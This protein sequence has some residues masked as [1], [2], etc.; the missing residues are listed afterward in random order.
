MSAD[1]N[2]KETSEEKYCASCG[3]AEL[4]EVHLK[5][6]D[7]CDL[8]KYCSVTCQEDHRPE[9]EAQCKKRAAE[10][11]DESLFKQPESRHKGDCPICMIP[12]PLDEKKSFYSCCSKTVCDACQLA[13]TTRQW[14]ENM[15][16]TCP[17][18]RHPLPKTR[19]EAEKMIMNRI[20]ANDPVAMTQLG[21]RHL[22]EGDYERAFK[23]LTKAAELGNRSAHY[24]VSVIYGKGFGVEKDETKEVYHLEQAAIQ[25][26][27]Q[28]RFK[29]GCHEVINGETERAVKHWII[30][31]SLGEGNSING[32]KECYQAG[33]ISK[34]DFAAA[35][36]AHHAAVE[37]TKS[38]QRDAAAKADRDQYV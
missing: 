21:F 20:A 14:E 5:E 3:I 36:R 8:V 34:D 12:L 24:N 37:A 9:H 23:Y 13:N 29:L 32:L 25:G 6:C 17:F 10:L 19:E 31:A 11:R 35:L 4:D 30:A 18:C 33:D 2:S 26:H 16:S 7:G 1:N 15:P 22:N 38:P 28:A 27:P